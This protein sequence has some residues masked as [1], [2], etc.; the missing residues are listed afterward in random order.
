MQKKVS[1]DD[2][3]KELKADMKRAFQLPNS[4]PERQSLIDETIRRQMY[5]NDEEDLLDLPEWI[6]ASRERKAHYKRCL[7]KIRATIEL[8]REAA[9][10]AT[11]HEFGDRLWVSSDSDLTFIAFKVWHQT[12]DELETYKATGRQESLEQVLIEVSE[13]VAKIPARVDFYSNQTLFEKCGGDL[14]KYL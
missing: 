12:D 4:D 6:R 10:I 11:N 3:Q 2:R 14:R 7:P 8:V 13:S 5:A 9:Q 1:W